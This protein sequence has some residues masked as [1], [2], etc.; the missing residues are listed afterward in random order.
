MSRG[1]KALPP[2]F[3][4]RVVAM[5]RAGGSDA[6]IA[7]LVPPRQCRTC[8][9]ETQKRSRVYCSEACRPPHVKRK[10]ERQR[11]AATYARPDRDRVLAE[12]V[13]TQGGQCAACAGDGGKRG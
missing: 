7:A 10:A 11:G 6:A 3:M 12:L 8:G 1:P 9:N 13:E 2:E 4:A 5:V